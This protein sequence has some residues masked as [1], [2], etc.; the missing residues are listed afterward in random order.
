VTD[1]T[2]RHPI[3]RVLPGNQ[4][5][6][7]SQPN[8]Q[9]MQKTRHRASM[10]SL[11]FCVRVMLPERHQWKSTVQAAAVMLKTPPVDSQSLASQPRPLPIYGTQFENAP[12]HP[13]VTGQQRTQ[14][15]PR[16]PFALRRHI[17]GWTQACN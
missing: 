5:D 17:A 14:T 2:G 9:N 15:Q 8:S 13:P 4:P 12:C 1:F 16:R 7:H 3:K 11:T 6:W 10:Y